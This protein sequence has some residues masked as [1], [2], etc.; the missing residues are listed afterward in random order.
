MDFEMIARIDD[1]SE[2][3]TEIYNVFN[4]ADRLSS[5]AGNIEFL[6]T[7]RHIEQFLKPGMKIL[8]LGAGTGRYSL[9]FSS[10][11]YD[12]VAIELVEKHAETIRQAKK[13]GMKLDVIQGNAVHLMRELPDESFDVVLCFGPLYHLEKDLDQEECLKQVRR[14]CTTQG[15][16][17]IATIN[18]D[19]VI[20]TET[21]CYDDDYLQGNNYNPVTF[22]VNNFP[23]VFHKIGAVREL[24]AKCG[25]HIK[26]EIASDGLS[27]LLGEKINSMDDETYRLWLNYHFYTCEQPE[28][29]G[30]SNHLLFVTAK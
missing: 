14:I 30:F 2:R 1:E 20:L 25:L 3:I 28:F 27:E 4:E 15:R 12:V 19:M 7:V 24:L 13:D 21:I 17:Y 8:D 23:F 22:K 29:I 11:G 10:K 16:M 5:K 26:A 9:Y 18:N 6:T